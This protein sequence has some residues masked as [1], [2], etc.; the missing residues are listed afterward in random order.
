MLARS[1]RWLSLVLVLSVA[2]ATLTV[3]DEPSTGGGN[4]RV[5][6]KTQDVFELE[7][8]SDPQIA[9]DGSSIVYVRNFF[10]KTVDQK[11]STL[12]SV[13]PDGSQHQVV[14]SGSY[15]LSA[16]RWSPDGTRLVYLSK[17]EPSDNGTEIYCRWVNSNRTTRL[18]QLQRK[19]EHVTWSPDGKWLAF[20][21]LVPAQREPLVKLPSAPDGAEWAKPPTI[22]QRINF[23]LDGKGY[24]E[25]AYPQV[26][27]L[28]A[29]G[30]TPRQITSGPFNHQ[31]PLAWTHDGAI[32][33][34]A[35]LDPKWELNPRQSD[36]YEVSVES[37]KL[38]RLTN[39]KGPDEAPVVSPNGKQIAWLGFDDRMIGSQLYRLYVMNRDGS[40]SREIKSKLDRSLQN[41]RWDG[42]SEGLYVQFDDQGHTKLGHLSTDEKYQEIA[43]DVGGTTLGRPYQS[44]SYSVSKKGLLAFTRTDPHRPADVAIARLDAD[45][46][47]LTSLNADLFSQRELGKVEEFWFKSSLDGMKTQAWLVTPPDFKHALKGKRKRYPMILEIHGGPFA[48]Y[49]W[50]FSAEVQMYAAA[51][52]VVLYVNPRGSTSYGQKYV[53]EIHHA[54]PGKDYDDLMSAVDSVVDRGFVDPAQLYVTGGSGGGILTAWVVGKTGRFRAAVAAKPVINWYSFV[55][56]TDVYPYFWQYWFSGLPWEKPTE[57]LDRSPISLVGN[58]TTPT[59]LMT[60]ENDHRTPI[61]QSEEFYQALKL[62]GIDTALV[63][64]P[65]ASHAIVKRPSNMVNKVTC[66]LSWFEKYGPGAGNKKD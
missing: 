60:G 17:G 6:L 49:G 31:G 66:I 46:R 19:P 50:R 13:L 20:V 18:T 22:I 26:F 63:R 45:S 8:A 33:F 59:M 37:G 48:N 29:E 62:R 39:R 23:R 7:F 30:G 34:S 54:Y 4:G 64:I 28:P 56:T 12:W 15:Q 61:T 16:P 55:L 41:P 9:P 40:E 32:L 47:Y 52:Y 35:N 36:L 5:P 43:T 14:E 25:D 44:G 51:G 11:R 3:A 2:L 57:Y 65:G 27:V 38:R 58:V 42:R 10:D 53:E 1:T 24:L 21:M